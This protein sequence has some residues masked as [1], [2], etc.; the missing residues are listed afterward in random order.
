MK[1]FFVKYFCCLLL[2]ALC[3]IFAIFSPQCGTE[4]LI[5]SMVSSYAKVTAV[6]AAPLLDLN[7][8]QV[9]LE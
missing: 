8:L 4:N 6:G 2:C 5:F 7:Q 1:L 3:V 9:N